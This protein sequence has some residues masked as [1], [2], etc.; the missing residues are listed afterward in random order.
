MKVQVRNKMK[1]MKVGPKSTKMKMENGTQVSM[2]K[3]HFKEINTPRE[4]IGDNGTKVVI[5]NVI[6]K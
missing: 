1:K 2:G 6:R 5:S 3:N 4:K